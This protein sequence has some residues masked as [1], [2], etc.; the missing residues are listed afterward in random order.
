[1]LL[2]VRVAASG[3]LLDQNSRFLV[4]IKAKTT[5]RRC[6]AEPNVGLHLGGVLGSL[7]K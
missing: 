4:K 5:S 2:D 1:M 3:R 6:S 7:P